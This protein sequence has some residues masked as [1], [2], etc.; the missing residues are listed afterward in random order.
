M[1]QRL[2]QWLRDVPGVPALPVRDLVMDSRQVRPGDAFIALPG[3]RDDGRAH[4]ADAQ[5]RGAV[6]AL[7]EHPVADAALPIVVVPH[8]KRDAGARAAA[9]YGNPGQSLRCIGVT[10][11]NGKTSIAYYLADL[12]SRLGHRCG[13]V[14]TIGWG[15]VGALADASLTTPD[16]VTLQ[17]Q[18]AGLADAG[19]HWVAME[20]SSHALAQGR[21]DAVPFRAAAFSNLT[22]D[23]LDYHGTMEAYGAAK[24]RLFAWPTL[25]TAV[26]N[27]DDPFGSQL[28]GRLAP[29][30][31]C[32]T[33]GE[34]QVEA[35]RS[36]AWSDLEFHR[37]GATGRWHTPW[38]ETPFA[39]PVHAAF[40]V[41]NVAVSLAL[42]C[43]AGV[44]LADVVH[45]ART[46]AQVP[47]R[48]EYL[49]VAGRPT[50]VIDFAHT[51]DAL[52]QVL[53]TLRPRT[54]GRLVCV[55]GC[56]G[57]RDRGKRPL[58]AAAAEA[59]ADNV[60]LTSD[61]PRSEDP[62]A[63]IAD[64][65]AGLSGRACVR[66]EPDR[67]RAI[68]SAIG[69]ARADDLVVIAGKGHESYQEIAGV[70]TPFSDREIALECLTGVAA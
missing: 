32:L 21:V 64:M 20:V 22:R 28:V 40:S 58:M 3:A 4:I 30:V 48:L 46:L 47:G 69:E 23:H 43:A 5:R 65:R 56:G 39:L 52:R 45:A 18:L 33:C 55:F 63:I 34:Y 12:A 6:A 60:W 1:M 53:D 57:D 38:G 27:V 49:R 24:A 26:L 10:G 16:P 7:V 36:V 67:R 2:D 68:A 50:V 42:L 31:R 25:E 35:A 70:R 44:P 29:D 13:Y 41:A 17:R 15:Q 61:N 14:G 9:F 59:A 11:T 66:E 51:P 54:Q 37:D 19:C 62:R 8:L